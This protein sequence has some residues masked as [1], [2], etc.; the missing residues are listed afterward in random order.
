MFAR[1]FILDT[2]SEAFPPA[3]NGDIPLEWTEA[4]AWEEADSEPPDELWRKL[5]ANRGHDGKNPPAC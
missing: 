2:V 3:H 5:C 4:V 1:E